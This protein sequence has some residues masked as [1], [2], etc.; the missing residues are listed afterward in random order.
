MARELVAAGEAD[1]DQDRPEQALRA[2]HG[3]NTAAHHTHD[4]QKPENSPE[5]GELLFESLHHA[6][7]VGLACVL[8]RRQSK[9]RNLLEH[10]HD[11]DAQVLL[12]ARDL[13]VPFTNNPGRTRRPPDQDST[14][15]QRLPP[16]RGHREGL[17]S[18]PRLHFH[19]HLARRQ[20]P[21]R[22]PRRHHRQPRGHH[23]ST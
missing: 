11:R 22:A 13:S 7:L 6:L 8:G 21:R 19:R 12:F 1:P 9:T 23:R 16:F 5:I 14:Q 20:H 18:H 15:D 4:Q 2:L 3:L 10:L 17:A